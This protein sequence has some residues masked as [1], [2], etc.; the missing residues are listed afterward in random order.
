MTSQAAFENVKIK[1]L[2][3]I[4][5]LKINDEN[6][7]KLIRQGCLCGLI[8]LGTRKDTLKG[9]PQGSIASPS[10]TFLCLNVDILKYLHHPPSLSEP[11]VYPHFQ[12]TSL[13]VRFLKVRFL[14]VRDAVGLRDAR[15]EKGG[16]RK[17]K[18]GCKK[19]KVIGFL[20]QSSN[21]R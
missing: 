12:E 5:R 3:N 13:K 16:A 14:K 4:L 11:K 2:I 17:E 10:M 9:T 21:S 19:R 1:T 15:K 18:G 7:L 20:V 6:F 8:E